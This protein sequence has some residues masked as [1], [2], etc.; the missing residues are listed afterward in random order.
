M[1]GS[2]S[3]STEKRSFRNQGSR[4][5]VLSRPIASGAIGFLHISAPFSVRLAECPK[6]GYMSCCRD[7]STLLRAGKCMTMVQR[8][9]ATVM[10]RG[11]QTAHSMNSAVIE[12]FTPVFCL[13]VSLAAWTSAISDGSGLIGLLTLPSWW[14]AAS[15]LFHPLWAQRCCR[16]S[17]SLGSHPAPPHARA[18]RH[19]SPDDGG[20]GGP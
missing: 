15:S 3:G 9:N 16:R 10:M 8:F 2:F 12:L 17:A 20:R 6:F 13:S 1:D 7:K 5:S 14:N 11:Q 19:S 4:L 18:N